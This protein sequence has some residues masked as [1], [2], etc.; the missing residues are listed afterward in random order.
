MPILRRPP[1]CRSTRCCCRKSKIPKGVALTVSLLDAFGAPEGLAV[2]CMLETPRGILYAREIAAAN[3]R[4]AALV[5]GTSDLTKDLHALPTRDR[6]PLLTSLSLAILSARTNSLAI[7]DG[8]HLDLSDDEG[9]AA[10]CRQGR[11]LGFDGKTL[12]HPKQIDAAN[13]AFAPTKEEIEWSRRIIAA[14]S[15]A[16]AAGKGVALVDGRLIENLHVES[17]NRILALADE[18]ERLSG[19]KR[20]GGAASLR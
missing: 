18:I 11:E 10:A 7:L 20:S 1:R 6:L 14:H 9:L 16:A 5:L 3:P 4:L 19:E 15:E 8:V 13:A 17:A 12:I 2:W